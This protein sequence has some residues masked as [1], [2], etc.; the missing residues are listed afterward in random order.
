M[1]KS[2]TGSAGA[3]KEDRPSTPP[4]AKKIPKAKRSSGSMRKSNMAR[5]AFLFEFQTPNQPVDIIRRELGPGVAKGPLQKIDARKSA[6]D[7]YRTME[8][9]GFRV[10]SD[11]GCLIPDE[12][13]CT[14]QQGHTVKGHQR[15]VS[16]FAHWRPEQG[17]T[18][19]R[20]EWGWPCDLQ[21]SHLCHRR[22]CCRLDHLIVEEQWRNVKR[23]FC[24]SSGACDCGN[25]IKC[26]R[27]YDSKETAELPDFVL[28]E[29][30]VLDLLDGAPP[31]VLHPPSRFENRDQKSR[32]RK[33]NKQKRERDQDRHQHVTD[34]KQLRLSGHFAPGAA[35]AVESVGAEVE[36]ADSDD[37]FM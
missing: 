34:R 15:T 10:T 30:E 7:Q 1:A 35:A 28:E 6:L 9:K 26:K 8:R 13:Y 5:G 2:K 29:S 24:G 36:V 27:R 12:Q 17:E 33:A 14:Y 37:D 3:S 22:S 25:P 32:Q 16:F 18:A 21:V 11:I 4:K 23:N 31:F 20:N 19:I